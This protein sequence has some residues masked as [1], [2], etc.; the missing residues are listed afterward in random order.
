MAYMLRR[1]TDVFGR[2]SHVVLA[3]GSLNCQGYHEF[4][5]NLWYHSTVLKISINNGENVAI[6]IQK[7]NVLTMYKAEE[8]THSFIP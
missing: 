4:K 7:G 8:S 5:S 6:N 1:Y 3:L 2:R